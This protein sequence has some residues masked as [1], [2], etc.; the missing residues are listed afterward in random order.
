MKTLSRVLG[1][2]LG[3]L[4]FA[5]PHI[6]RAEQVDPELASKII[7]KILVLDTELQAK[8]SGSVRI[9]V[10]GS[11]G[12]FD[13]FKA[14]KGSPIDKDKGFL[15]SDVESLEALPPS[16][17]PTIVFVGEGADPSSVTAYTRKHHVLSVT[18]VPSYVE[19]GVTLGIGIENNRPKVI[20]NLTGSE[21]EGLNWDAKILKISKTIR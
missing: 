10:I 14:L 7:L 6:A 20:L 16:S 15:V 5:L 12:A 1:T 2:A 17:K 9:A 13:A 21:S 19:Q 3:T 11:S 8:T 18:N 4:L